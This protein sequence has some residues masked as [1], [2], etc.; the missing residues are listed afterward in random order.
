MS[1][2]LIATF[3]A[4]LGRNTKVISVFFRVFYAIN[5]KD[6]NIKKKEES[7]DILTKQIDNY[8][9]DGDVNIYADMYSSLECSSKDFIKPLS[10]FYPLQV[11]LNNFNEAIKDFN[12]IFE[13]TLFK[14][15]LIEF[16]NALAHLFAGLC[17]S[18]T[19]LEVNIKKASTHLYR[20][21]LDYYKTI[22]KK[23]ESFT[24]EQKEQLIEIR[25]L[26]IDSIG[27]QVANTNKNSILM[28]YRDFARQLYSLST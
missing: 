18:D 25:K 9:S 23:K 6:L 5:K 17:A 21:A 22:I 10:L 27:L 15:G 14:Q 12:A 26:E 24:H 8:L 7:I 28:A 16:N 20:G 13:N 3:D 4:R 19:N 1:K 2:D 11:P